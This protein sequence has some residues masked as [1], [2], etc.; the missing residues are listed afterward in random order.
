MQKDPVLSDFPG[1]R[2]SPKIVKLARNDGFVELRHSLLGGS[3]TGTP[4][5]G[6]LIGILYEDHP[7]A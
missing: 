1:F 7:T 4:K 5:L 3:F 2:V 6:F